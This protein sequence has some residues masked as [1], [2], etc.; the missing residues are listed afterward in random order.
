MINASMHRG[1][2]DPERYCRKR[3]IQTYIKHK[4][5]LVYM[6]CFKLLKYTMYI[7]WFSDNQYE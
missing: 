1:T 7:I 6:E 3:Q 4:Y 5:K 2:L